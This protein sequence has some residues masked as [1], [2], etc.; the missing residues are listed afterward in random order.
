[1][2]AACCYSWC[3][4]VPHSHTASCSNNQTHTLSRQLSSFIHVN[5]TRHFVFCHNSLQLIICLINYICPA[6]WKD[7][8]CISLGEWNHSAKVDVFIVSLIS[9]PLTFI[10]INLVQMYEHKCS[11]WFRMGVVPV[12]RRSAVSPIHRSGPMSLLGLVVIRW[13][14]DG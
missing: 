3:S 11:L 9:W 5:I 6:G 2:S 1:M 14:P 7:I 13:K 4:A 8:I 10:S 12:H